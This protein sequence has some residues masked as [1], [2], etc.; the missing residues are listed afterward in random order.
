MLNLDWILIKSNKLKFILI[1]WLTKIQ[2]LSML[3]KSD[4]FFNHLVKK[5]QKINFIT[6]SKLFL[7]NLVL[8]Q[9]SLKS[10]FNNFYI[11]S[12]PQLLKK[13][14]KL[15]W[16]DSSIFTMMTVMGTWQNKNYDTLQM[17]TGFGFLI[18]NF[19]LWLLR[20]MKQ[21]MAKWLNNNFTKLWQDKNDK[22]IFN[23][24]SK[25]MFN[26]FISLN[27]FLGFL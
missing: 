17:N 27:K 10:T 3:N 2:D 14:Q 15:I 11:L 1:K 25:N 16:K 5:L 7:I 18:K 24:F 19:N 8:I 20:Q 21:M 6:L 22:N 12:L 23:I 9:W 4:K 26:L 13:I